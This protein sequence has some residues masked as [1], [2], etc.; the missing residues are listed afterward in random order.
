MY[1]VIIANGVI[2]GVS[3]RNLIKPEEHKDK[4]LISSLIFSANAFQSD[5][6]THNDSNIAVTVYP[7]TT[8]KVRPCRSTLI[9]V[10]TAAIGMVMKNAHE[11][12]IVVDRRYRPCAPTIAQHTIPIDIVTFPKASNGNSSTSI[13]DVHLSMF[14]VRLICAR[15]NESQDWAMPMC[16]DPYLL[17]SGIVS[18]QM[19]QDIA[20]LMKMADAKPVVMAARNIAL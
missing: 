3:G 7:T 20:K 5:I 18:K 11:V 10:E 2:G 12:A 17:D 15:V 4:S 8:A 6:S 19:W 13:C 9:K 1:E 14:N 16:L